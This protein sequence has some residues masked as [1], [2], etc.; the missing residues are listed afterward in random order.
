MAK[1]MI[2][3]DV[4][5]RESYPFLF[6]GI[7]LDIW[8]LKESLWKEYFQDIPVLKALLPEKG[9]EKSGKDL[10]EKASQDEA[11]AMA[12][13]WSYLAVSIDD[14]DDY[15]TLRRRIYGEPYE[16]HKALLG[17]CE[18]I[19]PDKIETRPPRSDGL[20]M[21]E[22]QGFLMTLINDFNPDPEK[23]WREQMEKAEKAAKSKKKAPAHK[24]GE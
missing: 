10:V 16:E 19:Y 9:G 23:F 7:E 12:F 20:D 13:I 21:K 6:A 2:V 15:V 17:G 8:P 5:D 4:P 18:H 3:I 24:S 1:Q 11:A 22:L 14:H